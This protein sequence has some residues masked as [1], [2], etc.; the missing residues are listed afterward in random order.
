MLVLERIDLQYNV[1]EGNTMAKQITE[2]IKI[3]KEVEVII[4]PQAQKIIAS[5]KYNMNDFKEWALKDNKISL[6]GNNAT[7]FLEVMY[8]Q[9]VEVSK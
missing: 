8:N 1:I 3:K 2:N 9:N 4:T 6:G 7:L 5:S